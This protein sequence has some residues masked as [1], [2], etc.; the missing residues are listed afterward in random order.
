MTHL[1]P[2]IWQS[3]YTNPTYLLQTRR[4]LP[5]HNANRRLPEP[6]KAPYHNQATKRHR[7]DSGPRDPCRRPDA[8]QPVPI[9]PTT[10]LPRLAHQPRERLHSRAPDAAVSRP[11]LPAPVRRGR[12]RGQRGAQGRAAWR[13]AGSG[14]G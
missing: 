9:Q 12:Y 3:I 10:N 5:R 14:C 4:R 13:R 8:E 2:S 11:A 1:L 6:G 7:T